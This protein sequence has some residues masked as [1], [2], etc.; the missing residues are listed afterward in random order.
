MAKPGSLFIVS[1][2]SGAGKSALAAAV[3]R[4]VPNLRFSVSYT[5]RSP[6]GNERNGVEYYF[7]S[8]EEFEELRRND[9]LLEWANIYGNLYG[10]SRNG[11]EEILQRGEDVLLDIDVQGAHTLRQK[12]PEALSIFI[13]PPSFQV[14]RERLEKRKLDKK[15]VI[16]Q[17]LRI[18]CDEIQQYR[19]YDFLIINDEFEK[20]ADELKAIVTGSRCRLDVR[21][22]RAESILKTFGGVDVQHP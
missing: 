9:Q 10:T 11:I 19:H 20:S 1:G 8:P 6:R 4:A 12:C 7:V 18:A 22:E 5:T 17:R 14:L 3:L 21:A 2:P 13:L 15:Y 16:E